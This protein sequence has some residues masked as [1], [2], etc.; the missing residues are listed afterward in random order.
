MRFAARIFNRKSVHNIYALMS[1]SGDTVSQ[2][3]MLVCM[4]DVAHA[5]AAL[6]LLF[7]ALVLFAG[8]PGLYTEKMGLMYI[9]DNFCTK[10]VLGTF[11]MLCTI[12]TWVLL[13]CSVAMEKDPW[14]RGLIL[15]VISIPLPMGLGIVFFT[16]CRNPVLHYIYVNLFVTSVGFVHL[17][18]AYTALH[19]E[20][21]QTYFLLLSCTA[22]CAACFVVLAFFE[23][24]PSTERDAA[25]ILEY[26]AVVGFIILNG[27][28]T[29]RIREHLKKRPLEEAPGNT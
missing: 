20:F 9:S 29:D 28:S 3:D 12:P 4:Q 10:T 27:L 16:L 22:A 23:Q 25:V 8:A 21:L 24:T 18:V 5:A 17:A 6:Q 26:L 19:L 2:D 15:W 11:F 13:A 7:L 1:R 14:K